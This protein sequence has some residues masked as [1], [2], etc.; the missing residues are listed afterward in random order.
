MKKK[1]YKSKDTFFYNEREIPIIANV[2]NAAIIGLDQQ[3]MAQ[4]S[5]QNCK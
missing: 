1:I 3:G 4:I 5:A 2:N